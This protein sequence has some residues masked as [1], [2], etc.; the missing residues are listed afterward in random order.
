MTTANIDRAAKFSR[1][2]MQKNGLFASEQLFCDVYCLE[3]GQEQRVHAHAESD[4]IYY[5]LDGIGVFTL[6]D[7]ESEQTPGDVIHAPAGIAHGVRNDSTSRLRCL[8]V[9]A[10]PPKH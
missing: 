5:V 6:G 4:K 2:K 10:P 8:V 3:P 1:E 9:M 7:E